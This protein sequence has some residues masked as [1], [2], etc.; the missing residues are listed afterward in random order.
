MTLD[1]RRA[2]L[3]GEIMRDALA[4]SRNNKL[5]LLRA[6]AKDLELTL[7]EFTDDP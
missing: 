4:M 7:T 2:A 5:R 3:V 6:L 1:A